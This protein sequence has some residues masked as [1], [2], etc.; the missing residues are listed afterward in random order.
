MKCLK[1]TKMITENRTGLCAACRSI[2]CKL[3]GSNY[4]PASSKNLRKMVCYNCIKP[5][6]KANRHFVGLG[7]E[8]T[9]VVIYG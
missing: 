4:T 3:C 7:D 9:D 5:S 1:C 8:M 6:N 2:K